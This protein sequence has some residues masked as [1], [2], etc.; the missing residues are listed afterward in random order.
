VAEL[1]EAVLKLTVDDSELTTRLGELRREIESLGS[2]G[3]RGTSRSSA[4]STTRSGGGGGGIAAPGDADRLAQLARDLNLNTNWGKA[5]RVLG[6]VDADLALIGASQQFN[7]NAGWTAALRQ[8]QDISS[9]LAL[10]GA[11]DQVNLNTSW[12]TALQQLREID[13]DLKLVSAGEALNLNTSWTSAL[14]Q[15]KE[16]DGDLRLVSAG[17]SLNLNTSW[18]SALQQLK[19]IDAD[20]KL[21]SAGESLNLNSSWT[22]ALGQL[23]EIEADLRLVAAGE[24]LNLNSSWTVALEQLQE[25][26]ADLRAIRSGDA[27]NLR[28]SWT[29]AL[30]QL[31][32]IDNDLRLIQG[33]RDLNIATSWQTFLGQLEE[34]KADL[35][36]A[37]RQRVN[38]QT[39]DT[40]RGRIE[41]N[42][43][44]PSGFGAASRDNFGITSQT[45]AEQLDADLA[46]VRAERVRIEKQR[47]AGQRRL[48][49]FDKAEAK[50]I[51]DSIKE[52]RKRRGEALGNALIGGAFPALF[53]QGIG[54]SLGGA[55]GGGLGGLLGGNFGFGL[56]LV[57]TAIGQRFDD[58]NKALE[59]PIENFE[60]LKIA[61]ALS[62]KALETYAGALIETGRSAEASL[63]IQKDLQD[64]FGSDG[65]E[66]FK[67]VRG[68]T[69]ELNRAFGEL[70]GQLGSFIAGPLAAFL[71]E[72]AS[73]GKNEATGVRFQNLIGQLD[74][75]QYEQVRR[76]TDLATRDA[77]RA[78]GGNTFF[79]PSEGDVA[80]GREAGIRAAEEILGLRKGEEEV[81]KELAAL[82]TRNAAQLQ[83]SYRLI[84]AQVQGN[85]EKELDYLEEEIKL[86][87][88]SEL[89]ELRAR[90]IKDSNDPRVQEVINR[91]KLDQFR[92][93]EQRKLLP[94]DGSIGK[95]TNELKKLEER[96]TRIKVGTEAFR[97]L[98]SEIVIATDEAR[99]LESE[100]AQIRFDELYNQLAFG[101]IALSFANVEDAVKQAEIVVKNADFTV[102]PETGQVSDAAQQAVTQLVYAKQALE[103]LN[104]TKAIIEVE[105]LTRGF[106]NGDFSNAIAQT[107]A[108]REATAQL[109]DTKARIELDIIATGLEDG[110]LA[111]NASNV[112]RQLELAKQVFDRLDFSQI[113]ADA[114]AQPGKREMTVQDFMGA[115]GDALKVLESLY[116][117]LEE[118]V[119]FDIDASPI[120]SA[121]RDVI[122]L[123]Q[124]VAR[125]D[126]KKA[127]FTV[128]VIQQGLEN[129]SLD[130]TVSNIKQ[131]QDAARQA[132]ETSPLG[133]D[134]QLRALDAYRAAGD[135]LKIAADA[136]NQ[137]PE[138]LKKAA[139]QLRSSL[140]SGF[141]FLPRAQ[142]QS[143]LE[144]ARA[145]IERGRRS[146]ILR[147]NFGAA[148]RRRTFEAADFVRNI[149]RQRQE[150]NPTLDLVAALKE[151]T[152]AE[153]NIRINVTMNADGSASVT[154]SEQQAALL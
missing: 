148:G 7:L 38:A 107:V 80:K 78:R 49:A 105:V 66:G 115:P 1:G 106:A 131:L 114:L 19:E 14:Q 55:A 43:L 48:I 97:G 83:N 89:A 146:G 62:S 2:A 29:T 53:G 119:K 90:G 86:R 17:E 30:E 13:A 144:S 91:A 15:L 20:L 42:R 142:R 71:R 73:V 137:S 12:G 59:N 87:K 134:V 52:R 37:A 18:T 25:V 70:S 126:G 116:G 112:R 64:T 54:A 149:E 125:L 68:A 153:R 26:E 138:Q 100:V 32:E 11:G 35:D 23:R 143:L 34:V 121:L 77:Q 152:S 110:Q 147:P 129:L 88:E 120:A 27:L 151:N 117:S 75:R 96:L 28:T 135:R 81:E 63:L 36:A 118:P 67:E 145:D 50:A 99:K 124:E 24:S 95:A 57:G 93:D 141:K 61:G 130:D 31:Q 8:L 98:V 113:G 45:R 150:A 16:I 21:V 74:P 140:Q 47:A 127:Q 128:E 9:D 132:F 76:T 41:E 22:A 4:R 92:V 3:T 65:L 103:N 123:E 102:D 82:R 51:Q 111:K 108:L 101:D 94:E 6:E 33:G 84:A 79:P 5:L 58:I 69:D 44:F 109:N 104:N 56:S 85:K 10:I 46:R 40:V 139:E 39:K 154:Q 133:S 122:E 136:L 72:L 60:Q